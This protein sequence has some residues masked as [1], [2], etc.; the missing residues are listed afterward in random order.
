MTSETDAVW[1]LVNHVCSQCFGRLLARTDS[2]GTIH[3]CSDCGAEGK[4]GH[5]SLCACGALPPV[6]RVRLQCVPNEH[7]TP[8]VSSE[9]VVI[10][11]RTPA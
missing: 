9:I 11:A 4:G 1:S 2:G 5:E 8:D 3:R 7:R 10:E 6:S